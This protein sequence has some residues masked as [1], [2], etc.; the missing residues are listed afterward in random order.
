MANDLTEHYRLEAIIRSDAIEHVKYRT[1]ASARPSKHTERWRATREIGR[2]GFA[3][4]RSEV[5]ES[6]GRVRAL[7]FIDKRQ[8]PAVLDYRRE[9]LALATIAKVGHV[10][11]CCSVSFP[12]C[13]CRADIVLS[14]QMSLSIFKAGSKAM[15]TST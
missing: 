13:V 11:V 15:S 1:E 7:K 6:S 3:V 4:V 12:S 9:L 8:L 2:G 14:I 10:P 5:E